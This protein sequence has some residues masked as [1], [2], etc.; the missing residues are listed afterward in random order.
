MANPNFTTEEAIAELAKLGRRIAELTSL[1]E[2]GRDPSAPA[3]HSPGAVDDAGEKTPPPLGAAKAGTERVDAGRVA[4]GRQG[5]PRPGQREGGV[6]RPLRRGGSKAADRRPAAPRRTVPLPREK[7]AVP[8]ADPDHVRN[9]GGRPGLRRPWLT[10]PMLVSSLL[11]VAALLFMALMF[12]PRVRPPERTAIVWQAAEEEKG[13]EG[14]EGAEVDLQTVDP[15]PVVP[16]ASLEPDNQ[17]LLADADPVAVDPETEAADRA[18][19][20]MGQP[21]LGGDDLLGGGVNAGDLLAEIGEDGAGDAGGGDAVAGDAGG[22]AGGARFFGRQGVGR[23]ALFLCDNSNSYA[24]G[25]FQTVLIELS[26]AVGRMKPE[27][28]FHVVFFSDTAYKLLHPQGVDTFLPAT[29]ENKRKL[30]AWLPTV[31]LC[32]GGRGI[33]GA[34][35]L[36]VAL[37]PDVVYF[38]SDG[39]HADSVI[40]RMVGLPLDGTVVHTFG[41]QADVRDRR[42]GLP[43]PERVQE[44]QRCNNNMVRIAEAHRGTFTPVFISPQAVMAAA[45]R[46]VKKNRT[47]G[48]VWGITLEEAKP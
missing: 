5:L 48:A 39:D 20:P 19:A 25:G 47:R 26:R 36:A 27:Q 6:G 16:D 45:T 15:Q 24:V 8:A 30:D 28:S 11:H 12:L 1:F 18:M 21:V 14:E 29:P 23:T 37:K 4:Q 10:A 13:E 17:P 38:L 35:A 33:R 32:S 43:D 22:G 44:Q 34:G 42:T 2:G 9:N 41:M 3:T 46:P 7:G 31:E 40:D